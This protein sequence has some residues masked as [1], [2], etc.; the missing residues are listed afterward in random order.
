MSKPTAE[1]YSEAWNNLFKHELYDLYRKYDA[2]P[3]NIKR[4][5]RL[6]GKAPEIFELL[7]ECVS[8]LLACKPD[9]Y[10]I[11]DINDLII[12]IEGK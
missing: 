6:L 4:N 11:K 10:I 1:Q 8:I 3:E 12:E 9:S 5:F 2:F 7:E